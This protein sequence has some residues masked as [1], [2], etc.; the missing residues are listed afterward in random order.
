VLSNK[1]ALAGANAV[2]S[3]EYMLMFVY[4]CTTAVISSGSNVFAFCFQKK[5]TNQI[6][7][8]ISRPTAAALILRDCFLTIS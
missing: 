3:R 4:L 2:E 6:N 8:V 7:R 5:N 1:S